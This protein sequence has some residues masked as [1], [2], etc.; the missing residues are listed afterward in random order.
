MGVHLGL[1]RIA[2]IC[3]GP[4]EGW[5]DR[6]CERA[7]QLNVFG[8]T[9]CGRQKQ[10]DFICGRQPGVIENARQNL[11]R[12]AVEDGGDLR[13][14]WLR[15]WLECAL[16]TRCANAFGSAFNILSG[17][18]FAHIRRGANENR[19]GNGHRRRLRLPEF[20]PVAAIGFDETGLILPEGFALGQIVQ[21]GS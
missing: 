3:A 9:K 5:H 4:A 10:H 7:Q 18:C 11:V 2:L 15:G 19:C 1:Q 16:W 21:H 20:A 6:F 13:A 8:E 12:C 14:G 17:I